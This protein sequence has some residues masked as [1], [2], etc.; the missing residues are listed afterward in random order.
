MKKR[1]LIVAALMATSPAV[2]QVATSPNQPGL[3]PGQTG[4]LAPT[5]PPTQAPTT[6]VACAEEMTAT[7][8]NVPTG[9]NTDGYG[10]GGGRGAASP[11]SGAAGAALGAAG[12]A[13]GNASTLPPCPDQPPFNELCN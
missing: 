4:E 2:A 10:T 1:A 12:G 6:G 3:L 7:F 8:C 13:G 9:P 5:Q 11:G